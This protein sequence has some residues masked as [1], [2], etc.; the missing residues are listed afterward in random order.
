MYEADRRELEAYRR[1]GPLKGSTFVFYHGFI[2]DVEPEFQ[3]DA[4]M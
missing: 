4:K 2:T 3:P 1:M